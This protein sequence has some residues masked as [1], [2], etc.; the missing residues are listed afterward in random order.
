[1]RNR[2]ASLSAWANEYELKHETNNI[3]LYQ[4]RDNTTTLLQELHPSQPRPKPSKLSYL[5]VSSINCSN[6]NDTT[7]IKV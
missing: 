3:T 6:Q 7:E 1:M 4:E 5:Q 2:C